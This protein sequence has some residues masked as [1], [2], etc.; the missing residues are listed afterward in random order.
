MFDSV[1]I[2]FRRILVVPEIQ[3]P[4]ASGDL[5]GTNAQEMFEDRKLILIVYME[6]IVFE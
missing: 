2:P 1:R 4:A 6:I 3:T 5:S